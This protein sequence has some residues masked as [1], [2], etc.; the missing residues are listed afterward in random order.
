M[1]FN[2][3]KHFRKICTIGRNRISPKIGNKPSAMLPKPF[4]K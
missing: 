1:G 3:Y 2:T 4:K